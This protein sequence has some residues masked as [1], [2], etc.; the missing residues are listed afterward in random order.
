MKNT[1]LKFGV[2][3]TVTLLLIF[4]ICYAM[5][6]YVDPPWWYSILG[7]L[8]NVLIFV[9]AFKAFKNL[10]NDLMTYGDA[11]KIG[12]GVALIA[13]TLMGI[14]RYLLITSIDP[15]F[16]KES[17]RLFKIH[18]ADLPIEVEEGKGFMQVSVMTVI[19]FITTFFS[20]LFVA[21]IIG[22]F[23]K[24]KKASNK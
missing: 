24:T 9:Y 13:G 15:N 2:L 10:N 3:L 16:I 23:M 6:T 21:S 12:L 11:I 1:I 4:G 14:F 8:A 18:H 19:E 7:F 22:L 20:G 17:V 5:N